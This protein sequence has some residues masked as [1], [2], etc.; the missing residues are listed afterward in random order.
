M[1]K[2]RVW[3]GAAC[4]K[5]SP[6][7]S[8]WTRTCRRKNVPPSSMGGRAARVSWTVN[9]H[10]AQAAWLAVQDCMGQGAICPRRYR[11]MGLH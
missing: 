3:H 6:E 8:V 11:D 4:Q 2:M 9:S 1:Q 7:S 10:A 5:P